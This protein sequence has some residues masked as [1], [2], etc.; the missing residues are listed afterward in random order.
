MGLTS[1]KSRPLD[2]GEVHFRDSYLIVVAVEGA[3]TEKRY[4]ELFEHKRIKIIVQENTENKSAPQ[5]VIAQLHQFK[6]EYQLEE[7]DQLWLVVDTDRWKPDMLHKVCK[8]CYDNGYFR[9]I[10]NPCFEY[11]LLLYHHE[12]VE[13][14]S[15]K[16]LKRRLGKIHDELSTNWSNLYQ[17]I[18]R[19]QIAV[20]RARENDPAPNAPFPETLGTHVYKIVQ[21]L[22]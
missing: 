22:V 19:T 5:H 6:A 12:Q 4:F 7:D 13:P 20:K 15:C 3:K 8:D 16:N 1:K 11:W 9:A 2:R 14:G 10:S 21:Q 18:E 17:D